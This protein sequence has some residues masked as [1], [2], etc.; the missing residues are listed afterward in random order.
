MLCT[1][2]HCNVTPSESTVQLFIRENDCSS[3][4]TGEQ[5][6]SPPDSSLVDS[7][8]LGAISISEGYHTTVWRVHRANKL[9]H[10]ESETKATCE[11]KVRKS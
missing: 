8:H 7:V 2:A 3:H 9:H 10:S 5:S 11:T 4:V 6:S 1:P